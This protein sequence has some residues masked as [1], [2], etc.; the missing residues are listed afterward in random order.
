MNPR[1]FIS[2]LGGAAAWPLAVRAQQSTKIPRIGIIDDS[3]HWNAL[4]HGLRDLGYLEGGNRGA[5]LVLSQQSGTSPKHRVADIAPCKSE[6]S[7]GSRCHCGGPT[8]LRTQPLRSGLLRFVR[9]LSQLFESD[10]AKA[11]A[12]SGLSP[13]RRYSM[14]STS[15]SWVLT[16]RVAVVMANHQFHKVDLQ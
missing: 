7:G 2:L 10:L 3:P 16:S 14:S 12:S 1:E 8:A 4:R 5:Q 15:N 13:W 11:R 6:L 9:R